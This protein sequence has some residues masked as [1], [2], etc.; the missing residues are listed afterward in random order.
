VLNKII[1]QKK[2][3]DFLLNKTLKTFPKSLLLV[4]EK[5]CGKHFISYIISEYF[6]LPLVDLTTTINQEVISEIYTAKNPAFYLVDLDKITEKEQNV[7]L[8]TVE[9]PL[10]HMYIIL[11][12]SK[13]ALVLNTIKGRCFQLMFEPYTEDELVIFAPKLDRQFFNYCKTPGQALVGSTTNMQDLIA[14]CNHIAEKFETASLVNCLNISDKIAFKDEK[15]KYNLD[16]FIDV[17]LNCIKT[18]IIEGNSNAITMYSQI[19][20]YNNKRADIPNVNQKN[21][22]EL[23]LVEMKTIA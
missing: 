16:L 7:L 14:Y 11:V 1:G 6:E 18:K 19:I 20:N 15:D 22:F 2:I 10:S 9:E 5:G 13:P 4:G 17:L 8:K 23:L 12:T 21:L 3:K